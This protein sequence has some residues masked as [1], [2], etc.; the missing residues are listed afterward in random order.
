MGG[1]AVQALHTTLY[2]RSCS[3]RC[4][5]LYASTHNLCVC[6]YVSVCASKKIASHEKLSRGKSRDRL[7]LCGPAQKRRN[8][9]N[10]SEMDPD[11]PK[12]CKSIGRPWETEPAE[13]E[14]KPEPARFGSKSQEPCGTEPNRL[15]PVAWEIE[16][17]RKIR[18]QI[19]KYKLSSIC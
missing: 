9:Y 1:R 7:A 11:H 17:E 14:M 2:V 10:G 15:S 4:V 8:S 19:E 6:A 18:K 3:K 16:G 12:G 5:V 13:P